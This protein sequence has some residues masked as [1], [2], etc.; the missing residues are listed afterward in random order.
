MA[1]NPPQ[2][3]SVGSSFKL[4][5]VCLR[6]Q[7]P[8]LFGALPYSVV[9]QDIWGSFYTFSVLDVE[10]LQGALIPFIEEGYLEAPIRT[11]YVLVATG[12]SLCLGPPSRQG[13]EI[14][15]Y[16]PTLA[17]TYWG[18]F[19]SASICMCTENHD[20]IL[21]IPIQH[22]KVRPSLTTF[23][24]VAFLP[25]WETWHNQRSVTTLSLLE[26]GVGRM[27]HCALALDDEILTDMRESHSQQ[28]RSWRAKHDDVW[29]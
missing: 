22:H 18:L 29:T 15:T 10:F 14:Y 13:W 16:I 21:P 1:Y 3:W 9:P 19:I 17:F 20:S 24:S 28:S 4:V 25:Q 2:I 26:E 5:S 27:L 23:L 12:V 11:L 7:A 6:Q 8:L